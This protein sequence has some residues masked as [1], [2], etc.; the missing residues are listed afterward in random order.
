M[1]KIMLS[2][3]C[4]GIA[5]SA[6]AQKSSVLLFGELGGQSATTSISGGGSTTNTTFGIMPGVGYQFTDNWTFGVEGIFNYMNG[7]IPTTGASTST[8]N[9]G[10]GLFARYSHPLAG[11]FSWYL[12]GDVTYTAG[13]TNGQGF[14]QAIYSAIYNGMG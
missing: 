7:T 13:S 2:L 1:K 8:T 12:Q 6:N 4:A 10:G 5:L 11:V 3:L 9:A 14:C